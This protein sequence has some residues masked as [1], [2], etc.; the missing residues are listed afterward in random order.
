MAALEVLTASE[1]Y[2]NQL[3]EKCKDG[4]GYSFA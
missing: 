4:W 2:V 1:Y 3:P